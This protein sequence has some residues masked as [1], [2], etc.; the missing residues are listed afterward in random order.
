LIDEF[1]QQ[2]GLTQQGWYHDHMDSSQALAVFKKF[3]TFKG[4]GAF[5][6]PDLPSGRPRRPLD[7]LKWTSVVTILSKAKRLRACSFSSEPLTSSSIDS[8][9][10][11]RVEHQNPDEETDSE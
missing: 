7:R 8:N 10:R 3:Q 1:V 9:K 4:K 2:Q 5:S 6:M 11:A